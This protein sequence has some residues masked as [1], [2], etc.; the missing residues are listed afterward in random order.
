V[1]QLIK[2][3]LG[4][5]K[6]ALEGYKAAGA[7]IHLDYASSELMAETLAKAIELCKK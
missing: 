6:V 1:I 4:Y 3:N 7:I 2:K 5:L